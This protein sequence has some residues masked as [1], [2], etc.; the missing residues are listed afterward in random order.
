MPSCRPGLPTLLHRARLSRAYLLVAIVASI[1]GYEGRA[2]TTNLPLAHLT[3]RQ[4]LSHN[5]INC[6]VSDRDGYLWF[7]T[8]DGLTRYDGS[9]CRIFR[10]EPGDSTSLP[11]NTVTAVSLDSRGRLW[12][13]TSRALCHYDPRRQSFV[14]FRGREAG[15][16][17]DGQFWS[18]FAIDAA[19]RGWAVATGELICLDF[20]TM[21]T[22][23]WKMPTV[24]HTVKHA[25][26]DRQ[27]RIWAL[28]D[29]YLYRFDRST[30]T[31]ELKA[32]G[33]PDYRTIFPPMQLGED[34]RGRLWLGTW[35]AG[36]YLFNEATQQ[37]DDFPDGSYSPA[38]FAIEERGPGL[39][40]RF[41]S[42]HGSE[43]GLYLF[44]PDNGIHL[45]FAKNPQE[46]YSHNQGRG[47]AVYR[48]TTT[49]IIWIGTEAGVEMYNP[50]EFKFDRIWFPPTATSEGY[51]S[52]IAQNRDDPDLFYVG[53]WGKGL[54]EWRRSTNRFR[55]FG[56]RLK[57]WEVF[58]SSRDPQGRVWLACAFGLACY[59]PRT[60]RFREYAPTFTRQNI[61][62][63]LLSIHA[64]RDGRIWF[65]AN[66]E[67]LGWLDPATGRM[68]WLTL[69]PG[70]V[71]S[72]SGV[73]ILSVVEDPRGRIVASSSRAG[74]FRYDPATEQVEHILPNGAR[75][76]GTLDFA[77]DRQGNLYV[78][79]DTALYIYGSDDRL[80]R[81]IGRGN[82]L[83]P[84][85]IYAIYVDTTGYLWLNTLNSV[86]RLRPETGRSEVF[87]VEDGL[88]NSFIENRFYV[89]P[90]TGELFLGYNERFH[91][92]NPYA[93][94]ESRYPPRVA[95]STLTVLN[96][97][98]LWAPGEAIVLQ[99]GQNVVTFDFSIINFT[100]PEKN[101]LFYQLEGFNEEWLE[102]GE[103]LLTYTNLDPGSYTLHVRARN[104]DGVWSEGELTIPITV[105]PPF[106]RSWWFR[107]LVVLAIAAL[108]WGV[109]RY[110]RQQR[111]QLS[112]IRRRIA[113]DLH[114]DI[115]SGLSSIRFFSD[116]VK[117][118]VGQTHPE[119]APLLERMSESATAL[120]DNMRDIVWAIS[121]KDDHLEHLAARIYSF[122]LRICEARG[123]AFHAH[124]PE[125]L[126]D[127]RL[128]PDQLRNIYL[129]V[130]EAINNGVKYAD[131]T[132]ITVELSIA[133][134][135]MAWTVRD[136]GKGF[137]PQS[138]EA[139]NGLGNMRQRAEELGAQLEITSAPGQG[140]AVSLIR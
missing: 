79:M 32:G 34:S 109:T 59:D 76:V 65:G 107:S 106:Y 113:R 112:A 71:D 70:G 134:H 100:N 16:I 51:T 121:G 38:T 12:V 49:G 127:R 98:R 64:A 23:S 60:D 87:G 46:E 94:R 85:G 119:A 117:Y 21:A 89:V 33:H 62:N 72:A 9:R 95:L 13:S 3:T 42:G 135:R 69:P 118:Q 53:V 90:T 122:G 75:S 14:P 26:I 138:A 43:S 44:T 15:K 73:R 50:N 91:L 22:Q 84:S 137:D 56:A 63:K 17:A 66:Y 131:A 47:Y 104:G 136:N 40:P 103:H 25:Y 128:R 96:K 132:E 36:F 37:F 74:F 28:G 97:P 8:R 45:E 88:F 126:P 5:Y 82:G 86:Y 78:P 108:A 29:N 133:H 4:G 83:P 102:T 68:G 116:V 20:E 7:G 2:Q 41:W 52:S 129:I 93:L 35:G 123:I 80:R 30:G 105:I 48:D 130:K 101:R 1:A 111:R 27:Q 39:G 55:P 124:F 58:A 115:G 54:Y 57:N 31:F 139:G 6:I 10:H 114:D 99:P 81:R 77:F 24:C 67:G 61:A 110:R 19:G 11:D 125:P 92:V 18:A 140:A 120:G